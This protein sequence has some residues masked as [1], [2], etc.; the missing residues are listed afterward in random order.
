MSNFLE[1][2]IFRD[3]IQ[4]LK[5]ENKE[6]QDQIKLKDMEIGADN[7]NAQIFLDAIHELKCKNEKLKLKIKKDDVRLVSYEPTNLSTCTL[8]FKGEEYYYNL[9]G[10]SGNN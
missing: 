1:K 5:R 4:E 2:L 9:V 3:A 6:L 7:R 10:K 8:N